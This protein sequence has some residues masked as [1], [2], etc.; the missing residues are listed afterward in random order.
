MSCV[1]CSRCLHCRH[2]YIAH[3]DVYSSC[4][5]TMQ[6]IVNHLVDIGLVQHPC[7]VSPCKVPVHVSSASA[8]E[9]TMYT[10][11]DDDICICVVMCLSVTYIP[12]DITVASMCTEAHVLLYSFPTLAHV[13]ESLSL[14]GV[15]TM[16][17]MMRHVLLCH[18][19]GIATALS[20]SVMYGVATVPLLDS[21]TANT[22]AALRI[23]SSQ[24]RHVASPQEYIAP[25]SMYHHVCNDPLLTLGTDY[26]YILYVPYKEGSKPN[27]T[28]YVLRDYDSIS[29]VQ[30]YLP[31]QEDQIP[32]P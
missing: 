2:A 31:S 21:E 22:I 18:M 15:R 30:C 8:D 5:Y 14:V 32:P 17:L 16:D 19:I 7:R 1:L 27:K 23:P 24:Y 4:I 13:Q 11:T 25:V 12:A 20:K 10:V 29:T 6:H 9:V 26:I 28:L 3:T